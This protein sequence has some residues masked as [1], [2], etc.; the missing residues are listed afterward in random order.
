MSDCGCLRARRVLLLLLLMSLPVILQSLTLPNNVCS[1]I[2][3]EQS[4]L[5]TYV[6]YMTANFPGGFGGV[7]VGSSPPADTTLA[8]L[9]V[10]GVS[11]APIGWYLHNGTWLPAIKPIPIF[12]AEDTGV[13]DALITTYP[14]DASIPAGT[15]EEFSMVEGT[16]VFVK[17]AATNTGTTT[18]VMNGSL[19]TPVRVR[20]SGGLAELSAGDLIADQIY[21]LTYDGAQW[22]VLNIAPG[23]FMM[24]PVLVVST[25]AAFGW[26][27]YDA[28]AIASVPKH[29]KH[30]ILQARGSINQSVAYPG[31]GL[32][33]FDHEFRQSAL[34]LGPFKGLWLAIGFDAGSFYTG[35][36]Q[37]VCPLDYTGATVNFD[38]QLDD[39]ASDANTSVQLDVYIVGYIV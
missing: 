9:R 38:M 23:T 2:T 21:I 16:T 22:L 4:R 11:G 27:T 26:T 7:S 36:M 25:A 19:A 18:M 30:V 3:D 13:A 14:Y 37:Y 8:W 35:A 32:P 15:T 6:A 5:N 31:P 12:Y 10:D 34:G 20:T 17:V 29:A 1:L 28:N 33:S 24:T 39:V